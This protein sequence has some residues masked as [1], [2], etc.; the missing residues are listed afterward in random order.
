MA[1]SI[2]YGIIIINNTNKLQL[3]W[4]FSSWC[5]KL[6]LLMIINIDALVKIDLTLAFITGQTIRRPSWRKTRNQ[7]GWLSECMFECVCVC[8]RK[9]MRSKLSEKSW[10]N[11]SKVSLFGYS[12]LVPFFFPFFI[13]SFII[14]FISLLCTLYYSLYLSQL[15]LLALTLPFSPSIFC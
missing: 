7:I 10:E 4:L 5:V 15:L 13:F 3:W 11:S 1:W 9:R 6:K 8:V 12:F 2:F 14:F